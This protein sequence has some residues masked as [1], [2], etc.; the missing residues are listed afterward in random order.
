MPSE[1][2]KVQSVKQA[3]VTFELSAKKTRNYTFLAMM[4][5]AAPGAVATT[6]IALQY[7]EGR[8]SHSPF[9]LETI[10][11]TLLF[12]VTVQPIGFDDGRRFL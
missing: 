3:A 7:L 12:S 6:P 5:R 2:A 10:L 8:P 9:A 4:E 1:Y 11:R